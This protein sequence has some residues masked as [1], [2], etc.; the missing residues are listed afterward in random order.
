MTL[1]ERA[2]VA[3]SYPLKLWMENDRKIDLI[4]WNEG[5]N[6]N[7]LINDLISEALDMRTQQASNFQ[8]FATRWLK[9]V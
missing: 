9:V 5:K 6:R 8:Q 7:A 4:V 2:F 1:N 3:V